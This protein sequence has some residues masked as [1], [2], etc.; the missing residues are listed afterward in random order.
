MGSGKKKQPSYS[1]NVSTIEPAIAVLEP[2]PAASAPADAQEL[3][4]PPIATESLVE[5][6]ETETDVLIDLE[7]A[8]APIDYG[9]PSE[10]VTPI[11]EHFTQDVLAAGAPGK[12]LLPG[13]LPEMTS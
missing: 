13:S 5:G 9:D 6:A 8:I 1:A 10:L 4:E 11:T 7:Q 3:L 12:P 2:V